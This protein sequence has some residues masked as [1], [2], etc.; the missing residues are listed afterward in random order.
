MFYTYMWLRENGT[1]YYVGK[2]SG[3]RAYVRF[4]HRVGVPKETE[5]II[6]Q[7]FECEADAFFAE[8]LLIA[9]YGR[10][11][12]NTGCLSNLTDGGENPPNLTG[13]KH[14]LEYCAN[15]SK[16]SLGNQHWLGKTHSEESIKKM[17][18]NG[19]RP[20]GEPWT[21]ARHA[22]QEARKGMPIKRSPNSS[23]F[24][25]GYTPWNKGLKKAQERLNEQPIR[26]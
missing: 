5:R 16:R 22:A 26:S 7:E 13:V 1:P 21:A 2:G 3:R 14:S 12:N 9:L 20:K 6:V 19:G 25:K 18:L 10:T 23:H 17:K 24:A 11:D 15:I 4:G 8:K